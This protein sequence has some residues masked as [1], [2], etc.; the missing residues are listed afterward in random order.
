MPSTCPDQYPFSLKTEQLLIGAP[1]TLYRISLYKKSVQ[2]HRRSYP[3]ITSEIATP[4]FAAVLTT[5]QIAL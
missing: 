1:T 5:G 4:G 3:T 2:N